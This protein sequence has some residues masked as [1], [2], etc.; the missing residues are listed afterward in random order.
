MYSS[1]YVIELVILNCFVVKAL[2]YKGAT[3]RWTCVFIPIASTITQF[4]FSVIFG[5]FA[6]VLLCRYFFGSIA[7]YMTESI[8]NLGEVAAA[9]FDF[10]MN[11]ALNTIGKAFACLII[12]FFVNGLVKVKVVYAIEEAL[13]VFSGLQHSFS[14]RIASVDRSDCISVA[15]VLCEEA[16]G[17][18]HSFSGKHNGQKYSVPSARRG[19]GGKN[20]NSQV[21]RRISAKHRLKRLRLD[22]SRDERR[23]QRDVRAESSNAGQSY[24]TFSDPTKS[25]GDYAAKV[26]KLMESNFDSLAKLF[27]DNGWNLREWYVTAGISHFYDYDMIG[28]REMEAIAERM[29]ESDNDAIRSA[30][31]NVLD[32]ALHSGVFERAFSQSRDVTNEDWENAYGDDDFDDDYDDEEA[33]VTQRVNDLLTYCSRSPR[34]AAVRHRVC[35]SGG[36]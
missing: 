23:Q 7:N 8:K 5:I 31:E 3:I 9:R 21:S 17:K 19:A 4:V 13:K 30:A 10:D 26:E 33:L 34:Y 20:S 6:K 28:S 36:S 2:Q 16:G 12:V 25:S 29:L 27:Q 24:F 35:D 22:K 1:E 11:F 15:S 18:G 14:G 32:A